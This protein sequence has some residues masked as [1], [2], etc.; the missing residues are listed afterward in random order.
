MLVVVPEG[1]RPQREPEGSG[2]A[3]R[4]ESGPAGKG[5]SPS[6]CFRSSSYGTV[7]GSSGDRSA[8]GAPG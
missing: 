7:S 8:F 5:Y 3:L 4:P 1:P 6:H 2:G